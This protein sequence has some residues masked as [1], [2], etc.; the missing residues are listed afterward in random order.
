MTVA[1]KLALGLLL[2]GICVP[3]H[4]FAQNAS[5]SAQRQQQL[6]ESRKKV[7]DAQTALNTLKEDQKR[8]RDKKRSELEV[9]E[10]FKSVVANQK[11][12]KSNY[13]AAKKTAMAAVQTKP[14]YKQAV[15]D[16]AELQEKYNAI[17]Q[18]GAKADPDVI[19]KAGSQVSVKSLAIKKMETQGVDDDP[20]VQD[21][22]DALDIA[23]KDMKALDEEVDAVL[24][25][26]PEYT[27]LLTQIEQAELA[28]AQAKEADVQFRKTSRPPPAPKPVKTSTPKKSS[29]RSAGA[30]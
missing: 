24:T 5:A 21:A 4:A 13:D 8:I 29:R 20:K 2:A 16:K 18:Q 23:D 9:K 7:T 14:E 30:Y 27:A 11:K 15:K 17:L 12:A 10:E 19:A 28:V 3:T 6:N 22:K 1:C 26:D 25:T